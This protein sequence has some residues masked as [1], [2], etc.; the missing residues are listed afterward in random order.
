MLIALGLGLVSTGCKGNEG[1]GETPVDNR[2]KVV[3]TYPVKITAS[4]LPVDLYA[5]LALA[6]DGDADLKASANAEVPM[7]GSM[8]LNV[9]LS[10]LKEYT[11]ENGATVTGYFFKIAE[12]EFELPIVGKI[13]LSGT[14]EYDGYDG[15][16]YKNET[17][18]FISMEIGG[19]ING[20][21]GTVRVETGTAPT[22]TDNRDAVVGTYPV[23]VTAPVVGDL[24]TDLDLAKEGD[25]D[26]KVSATVEIPTLDGAAAAA[27]M[28]IDLVLSELKEYDDED[29]TAVAG[30]LFKI[31]EQSLDIMGMPMTL[32]GT[33]AYEDGYDGKVYRNATDSFISLEIGDESGNI[34]VKVETGVYT[35]PMEDNRDNVVGSYPVEVTVSV[36]P[37]DLFTDLTL[38]KEGDDNLKVAATVQ[39]PGTGDMDFEVELVLSDL[40]EHEGTR[41]TSLG[42]FFKIAEQEL[43]LPVV[44]KIQLSGTGAYDGYDGTVMRN[45]T[46]EAFISL[47][48]RDASGMITVKVETGFAEADARDKVV[49]TYSVILWVSMPM[50]EPMQ[51]SSELK[52]TKEGNDNLKVAAT[53]KLPGEGEMLIELILSDLEEYTDGSAPPADGF[54]FKIAPQELTIMGMTMPLTG[55]GTHAG[56]YDGMVY[57]NDTRAFISLEIAAQ[58]GVIKVKVEID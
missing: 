35:P 41:T 34:T 30:Y 58:G 57:R 45:G 27:G 20:A 25:A 11:D 36:V 37:L 18:A 31:A 19:T 5:D 23:K 54:L 10:E 21:P 3:G 47:E 15:K 24:Y 26:L 56:G 2:D 6:K 16:V 14:G 53:A 50:V 39:V 51:L 46:E 55:T 22:T 33:G 29:G 52:L 1:G 40:K 42:Y 49:G 28:T 7:I 44:G 48:I 32:S 8:G 43:E 38:T 9:L 17:D 4:A 13:Q 12:Q